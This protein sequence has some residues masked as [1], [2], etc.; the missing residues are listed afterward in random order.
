MRIAYFRVSSDGQSVEA[1]RHA[2]G[3]GFDR[4][5]ADEGVSGGVLAADRPGFAKLLEQV[6]AGDV[7]C[8]YAVDRLGRDAL[9]VQA[10]VKRLIES[11]VVVDVHGIG[12]LTGDTAKLILALLAQLAEMERTKIRER[13]AAGREAARA[14]LAATGRTHRGKL[15]LGRPQGPRWG[16]GGFLAHD[17]RREHQPNGGALR[18]VGGD[19]QASLRGSSQIWI[20]RPKSGEIGRATAGRQICRADH[21]AQPSNVYIIHG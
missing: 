6:R 20:D 19:R 8:V 14:S 21:V 4:E 10:T 15:S 18:F 1:Q 9:D 17:K 2:L 7:V 11:K 3:G 13:T 5:F 16:C 12:P